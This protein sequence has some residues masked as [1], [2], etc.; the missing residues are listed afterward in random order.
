MISVGEATSLARKYVQDLA[1]ECGVPLNLLEGETIERD[2]GWCFFF[3]AQPLPGS[4]ETETLLAGN[5]PV[6]IDRRDGSLHETGT[7]YPVEHYLDNYE[8]TG[9][10]HSE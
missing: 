4:R 9:T 6:I 8:R 3:D 7:A 1:R 5:A 2:F 10:P